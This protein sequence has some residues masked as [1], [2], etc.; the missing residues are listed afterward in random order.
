MKGIVKTL[1]AD[2]VKIWS[3]IIIGFAVVYF[4]FIQN[5]NAIQ[6]DN[7]KTFENSYSDMS[8]L[9]KCKS[10]KF[11]I[12]DDSEITC[13]VAAKSRSW[14]YTNVNLIIQAFK[15]DQQ[16]NAFWGVLC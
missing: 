4:L 13:S 15:A 8:I 16:N 7:Q 6:F 1:I 9:L 3:V 10:N 2:M 14:N 5:F 11:F 12:T